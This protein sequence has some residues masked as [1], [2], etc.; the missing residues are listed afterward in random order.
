MTMHTTEN[1]MDK[2]T[3]RSTV[4]AASDAV[5][6][7]NSERNHADGCVFDHK[8][9]TC[10]CGVTAAQLANGDF[11]RYEVVCGPSPAN[12]FNLDLAKFL[13]TAVADA[14]AVDMKKLYK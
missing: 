1:S 12:A 13:A 14:A 2:R 11:V 7:N 5:F 4:M 6:P 3:P 8:S 9:Y 10:S